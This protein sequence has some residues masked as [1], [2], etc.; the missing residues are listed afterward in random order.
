[1]VP[2]PGRLSTPMWPPLWLTTPWTIASPRPVPRSPLVLKDAQFQPLADRQPAV[3]ENLHPRERVNPIEEV[4]PPAL[5]LDLGLVLLVVV[6]ELFLLDAVGL[7]EETADLGEGEAQA[8]EK[9]AD[10]WASGRCL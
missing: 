10:A 8:F 9:L 5:G 6:D 4:A 7:E 3:V 1:V 2:A